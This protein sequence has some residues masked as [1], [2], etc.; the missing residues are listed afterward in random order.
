MRRK[1]GNGWKAEPQLLAQSQAGRSGRSFVLLKPS[2]PNTGKKP[3]EPYRVKRRMS[4]RERERLQRQHVSWIQF[5]VKCALGG[6]A[7]G[8]IS[9]WLYLESNFNGLGA[10]LEHSPNRLGF[11][12]LLT[13]SFA[14][15][16][17][18]IAMAVGIM[19]RSELENRDG[20]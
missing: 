6:A 16:F 11:T 9:V 12:A 2:V 5:I 7:F 8:V 18:A 14:F 20:E 17:G 13:F 10:M 3:N 15:T 19:L 4:Q 1:H